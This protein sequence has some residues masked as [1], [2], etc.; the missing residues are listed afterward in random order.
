MSKM[1]VLKSIDKSYGDVEVLKSLDL[2]VEKGEFLGII[3]ASGSGKST[4]MHIIGT[5]DA[6]DHGEVWIDHTNLGQLNRN[7]LADFRNR[8]IGFVFQFHH[9]LPEFTALENVLIP[10]LITGK[11]ENELRLRATELL[12]YLNL[13]HR[14][15]HKP[16]ELSGGEQQRVALARAMMNQP[17]ILLADEPTGNL[18]DDLAAELHALLWKMK[19]DFQQTILIVTH[20]MGLAKRCDRIVK[21]QEGKLIEINHA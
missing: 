1:I 13:S 21:L 10:G 14:F 12:D 6:P 16:S 8:R 2:E 15:E 19:Q 9:L 17:S 11:K 7:A 18:D 3:G 20:D 4:L 5:L